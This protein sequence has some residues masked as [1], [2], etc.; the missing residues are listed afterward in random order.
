MKR[1]FLFLLAFTL[2]AAHAALPI[3]SWTLPNG[4]RVLLVEHHAIPIIDIHL[5]FD[6]G[7]RRDPK[8]KSGLAAL[9]NGMLAHG[10]AAVNG[11]P[12]LTEA[13]ISDAFAD[14]AAQRGGD[15]SS[16]RAGMTLRTLS[17][18]R[19]SRAAILLTAR[20][21]A[22]PSF[23]DAILARD[24]KRIIAAIKEAD[25]KP[26]VIASNT[27]R[28]ALYGDHPY[29]FTPSVKSVDALTRADLVAFHR[30]HY[31]AARAVI[32]IV[33][34][35]TRAQASQIAQQLTFRLPSGKDTVLPPLPD[36]PPMPP[37]VHRIAHPAEQAHI[38]LG[39]PALKRGDPDFFALTVGNYI[40]GGGGFVSRLMH[41]VRE[42]RGLSYG[43]SSGFS[44]RLQPG[45]FTISLQTKKSQ[46]DEALKVTRN[47]LA[48][49][50]RDGPTESE[51][52]AAKDNLIGGFAL[53][54]DNN[55]KILASVA[56]IGY[57]H[58]PLNYLDTWTAN[59]AKVSAA[60]VRA[61]FRRKIALDRLSTV[62]VGAPE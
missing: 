7:S 4:A 38:L 35:A 59:V 1:L 50:L 27:F 24:K 6:A 62:I 9:T 57:Y 53:Q 32:T 51:M 12:A 23:P 44:P 20:M 54:L 49:F 48:A 46:T 60:D 41:E 45:P 58:L 39:M 56:I 13:Q 36:V 52:K 3:Q 22:Q 31:V 43:V 61:A 55:R 47:T 11:E 2:S 14:T 19:E 30:Q 10:I 17:S 21:L 37:S 5:D 18:Q 26:D 16:D 8:G 15:A 33:G 42:K 40:L 28:R 25:T 34:D 29:A